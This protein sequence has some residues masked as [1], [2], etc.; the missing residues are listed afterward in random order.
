MGQQVPQRFQ[1]RHEIE[2]KRQVT[3][4]QRVKNNPRKET[5]IVHRG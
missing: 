4:N 3:K 5:F 2:R 1:G